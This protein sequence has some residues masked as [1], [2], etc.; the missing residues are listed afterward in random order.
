MVAD[1]VFELLAEAAR[2]RF[3]SYKGTFYPPF[4]F[5]F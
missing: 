1:T 3:Y 5:Y 4:I 2:N